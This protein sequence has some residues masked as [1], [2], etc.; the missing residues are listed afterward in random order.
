MLAFE[1]VGIK[2]PN[3]NRDVGR[4]MLVSVFQIDTLLTASIKSLIALGTFF[5]HT[6]FSSAIQS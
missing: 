6:S 1:D 3:L 5:S 2:Q 4:R